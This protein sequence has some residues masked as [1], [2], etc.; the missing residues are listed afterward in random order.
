MDADMG[1][2]VCSYRQGVDSVCGLIGNG[3]GNKENPEF[4]L[5]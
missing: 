2:R 1:K 4:L 5:Q 3:A